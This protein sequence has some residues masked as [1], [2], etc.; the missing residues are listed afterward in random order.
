MHH[1]HLFPSRDARRS[2]VAIAATF[3][4]LTP[5][6]TPR[7]AAAQ[8]ATPLPARLELH[9][10]LRVRAERW[11][12]FDEG[13]AGE[14][15]FAGALARLGVER[16]GGERGFRLELAAPVLLRLPDDAVQ[17][18]PA[19]Q[20]G[21]GGTYAAA[22][23]GEENVAQLFP[24]NAYLR[25]TRSRLRVTQTLRVGRFEF[26]DGTEG[27]PASSTV[28][29]IKRDRIAQR[30]LGTF[31][32]SHVGRSL[33]GAH[34]SRKENGGD[35]TVVLAAPTRGVFQADGWGTLPIGVA[36]GSWTRPVAPGGESSAE[37]RL[38]A[39]QYA[40]F[41]DDVVK[42]DARPLVDRTADDDRIHVTTLG[43]HWVHAIASR[44][45]VVDV[46]LWGA[47][48]LGSWGA[49]SHRAWAG[50]AELGV[51]PTG[52]SPLKPWLRGGISYG[53]GDGDAADDRH[54]TFFQVLPTPRPYARF[55]FYD[56]QNSTD[57]YAM[58]TLRP[59]PSFTLRGEAHGIR[60][61]S[62]EDL[63]YSG[64]GAFQMRS[65]G[66]QGRPTGGEENL[67]RLLDL[68][69][70]LRITPDFVVTGYVSRA[71]ARRAMRAA[72]PTV[73]PGTLVYLEVE[74][75]F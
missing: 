44:R 22:N 55:P 13:E 58:L 12:W 36:Y 46:T 62:G 17:P 71:R 38:F 29:T 8:A 45:G 40:D 39:L 37:V 74:R 5:I 24:K 63:W 32:W 3:G 42:T 11:N 1:R 56:M 19:G 20:L 65:F 2:L 60:L 75:R 10:G 30:L 9:G 57:V 68:S 59:L 52:M 64:G 70:E 28:A 50:V 15:L 67:A 41:R 25:L 49:Q 21:L 73:E 14:Y 48:Q 72:Y 23:F 26:N 47:G 16:V 6:A 43:G 66:Y 33:D 31:G 51:Q 7:V 54:G 69:A 4:A 27:A 61:S 34:W 53:S 35:M 18:A